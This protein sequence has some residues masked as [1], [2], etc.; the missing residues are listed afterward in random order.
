VPPERGWPAAAA[1]A[2]AVGAAA[3][4]CGA[5]VGCAAGAAAVVGFGAPAAVGATVAAGAG[6]DPAGPHAAMA[7]TPPVPTSNRSAV[8][9]FMS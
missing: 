9:L 1:C 5:V 7:R 4:A 3:A 8:R 6:V 2:A